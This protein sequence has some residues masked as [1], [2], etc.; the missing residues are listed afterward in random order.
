MSG[1]DEERERIRRGLQAR[2]SPM[3]P[4]QR[5]AGSRLQEA[6]ARRRR[7]YLIRLYKEQPQ[8]G[9]ETAQGEAKGQGS[10]PTHPDSGKLLL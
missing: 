2:I 6:Y 5:D 8:I 1:C 7:D 4:E 10:G 3:T 9:P